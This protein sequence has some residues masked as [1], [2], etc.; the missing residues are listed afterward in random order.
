MPPETIR[1]PVADRA[2]RALD[3]VEVGPVE[4]AVVV[5]VGE[6]EAPHALARS[7]CERLAAP[8]TSAASQPAV[9][10][11][12]AAAHVDR[13]DD[14]LRAVLGQRRARAAAGSVIAAVPITTRSA[15]GAER[16]RDRLG[17]AQ[18]AAVLHGHAGLRGD[19]RAGARG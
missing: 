4:H 19:P 3:R 13:H 7:A 10:G 18:A 16:L 6:D 9:G 17:G 2:R 1:L 12:R 11:D 15:P 14:A 8:A 5:D